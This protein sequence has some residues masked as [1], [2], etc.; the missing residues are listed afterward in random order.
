MRFVRTAENALSLV[1][2]VAVTALTALAP[3]VAEAADQRTYSFLTTGN[4]HGFQIYDADRHRITQFLEHPYRYL[5]P[6]SD[7]KSDGVGRRNLAYDVYFG[8][9]A[10]GGSGWLADKADEPS[11]L[12]ETNVI[13]VKTPAFGVTAE[14]YFFSP[15]DYEGNAMIALLHAPGASDGYFLLNFHMGVGDTSPDANGEGLRAG[16]DGSIVETGPG[17]GAMVYVPLSPQ[18]RGDCRDV[19]A[20]GS[21]GQDLGS[22]VTCSGNDVVAGVQTKLDGDGWMAVAV[23]FVENPSDADAAVAALRTWAGAKKPDAILA[24][25]LAEWNSWRKPP[26]AGVVRNDDELKVWRQS[27]TTLR[28]GQSREPN[29]PGRKNHGMVLASLP[30]G[31]WH[32]G[33]VR[34]AVYGIVALAR[35]GH[36]KEAKDGL[37]F[38]FNAEPVGKFK[39]YVSNQDYRVSVVRYFGTG[40]EEADYSG[41]PTPNI[42][43]DGWGLVLWGARQYVDAANDLAWLDAPTREGTVYETLRYGIAKP[44][45]GNMESN[46]IMKA[47]SSIWE[48]HDANKRHFAYTTMTAI[49][50]LCDLG[51]VAQKGNKPEAQ[52]YRDLSA[53]MRKTFLEAFVDPQ[54]AIGGSL[55]ELSTGRYTDAAVAEVFTWNILG[56]FK[57]TQATATLDLLE[58]LRVDS[59]GY[60]RNDD[61]LSSYD[62]NEWILVD[63]RIANAQWRAGRTAAADGVVAGIVQKARINFDVLPELYNAVPQDGQVGKY[64][65]SIP[66]VGYGGGAYVMTLLDRAGIIEPNDCGDGKGTGGIDVTEGGTNLGGGDGGAS[67]AG[68]SDQENGGAPSADEVP[69]L[70]ACLC[71]MGRRSSAGLGVFAASGG[72]L[73]LSLG[74]R[75]RRRSNG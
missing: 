42:E 13:H 7:P 73:G 1:G 27:E 50:G 63:L 6:R 9:K 33:W 12:E 71:R 16:P 32:S 66:M 14:S 26:A 61:G 40:E 48:V 10:P 49:R 51:A 75:K 4:G 28:M 24:G 57:S 2:F 43:T 8:V 5:R 68:P 3:R 19:F 47:D 56:D 17:G 64:T 36:T 62:N 25:T 58:K 29:R 23:Q 52:K 35:M 20:R 45:E 21:S 60:K 22:D 39:S 59:G 44:I 67:T 41:Q 15:F 53:K 72:I 74:R 37:E 31:E 70:P 34:D 54:G 46:G 11:Y 18:S 65:G 69:Y 30:P 38:F 55:E